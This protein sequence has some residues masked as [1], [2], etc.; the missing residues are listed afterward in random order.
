MR[1]MRRVKHSQLAGTWY[2]SAGGELRQQVDDWLAAA[3]AEAGQGERWCA[4]V[5]PHAGYRYSGRAAAAAYAGLRNQAY[6]R[7][8]LLAPSHTAA[9][10]GVALLDVD[11]F[12]TPLGE[13]AVDCEAVRKLAGAP[14]CAVR[15][16]VYEDEHSLEIQL[17]F[18]QR[19]LPGVPVVPALLGSF[20]AADYA[21]AATALAAVM[22][23]DTLCVVSSD[24]VHY[25]WRFSY[26]PFPAAGPQAVAAALRVLDMGAIDR[27][28]A[29]DA[30]A[31][32][33]YME[34]TGATICGGTPI[35]VFL[36]L[37]HR[38]TR[39]RLLRYYT[40]LD[41][42]GDYEHSVSYASIGFPQNRG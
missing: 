28:C 41:V 26:L 5:V 17:P 4:V 33:A 32:L 16:V 23:D 3:Q 31:F 15:P 36:T 24:F 10:R 8:L 13:V 38:R 6:S 1:G 29:G 20:D 22:A 18:L 39:G 9:F 14:L 27:V 2:P 35:A 11:A 19:A 34:D 42:T 7:V 30:A 37:H 40:S 25:G 12:S 21:V